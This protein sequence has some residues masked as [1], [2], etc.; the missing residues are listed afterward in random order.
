MVA[1]GRAM[2]SNPRY[3]L[4]DEPSLASRRAWSNRSAT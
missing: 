4:L 1:M 2:M 3:L